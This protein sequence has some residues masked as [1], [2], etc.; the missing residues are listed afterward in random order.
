MDDR[1]EKEIQKKRKEKGVAK[2]KKKTFL[3]YKNSYLELNLK[4][5]LD[6]LLNKF[7]FSQPQ[8]PPAGHVREKLEDMP[9]SSEKGIYSLKFCLNRSL[10]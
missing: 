5:F 2:N 1:V 4:T 3:S 8:T 7:F 6:F 10:H 9:R